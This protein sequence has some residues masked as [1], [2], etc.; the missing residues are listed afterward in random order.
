VPGLWLATSA[1]DLQRSRTTKR[2][3]S[4]ESAEVVNSDFAR[5]PPFTTSV[6]ALVN[7]TREA[8]LTIRE[9]NWPRLLE[10]LSKCHAVTVLALLQTMLP[11]SDKKADMCGRVIRAR[12]PIEYAY[13]DGLDVRDSRLSNY[14][15]RWNGSPSQE[16]LVIR[17]N[18]QSGERSLD[19]L[20]WG[21]IPYWC[22]DPKGGRK[23]I[24]AK[25]ETVRTCRC[26]AK[27]IAAAAFSRSMGSLN[28]VRRKAA[29][30]RT[31]SP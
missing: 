10:T 25:A 7:N 3:G 9:R 4:E 31:R 19:L 30:S 13:V 17:Q 27:P 21:L 20:K 16:F 11:A 23:P 26:F 1:T 2:S 12:G 22:K 18:H 5:A 15:R 24:N 14:P 8:R 6:A 29:N 28:G